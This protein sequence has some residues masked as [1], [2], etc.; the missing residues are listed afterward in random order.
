ML[1]N[2]IPKM[3]KK[4]IHDIDFE[5]LKEKNIR[6]LLFDLDNTVLRVHKSIPRKDVCDLMKRLKKDFIVYIVSNNGRKKRL[7]VASEK[8]D[9]PYVKFAMKPLPRGFKKIKKKHALLKSEMCIIG[10]QLMT[11]VLGGN[12]YGIYTIL[13]DP[14]SNDEL[15]V[16]GVNRTLEKI[17]LRKLGKKNLFKRGEYYG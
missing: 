16:T 12:R 6:C 10:D 4:S 1:K 8:L 5:S 14:L 2:Y 7:S 9:I 17:K 13:V 3:Y 11:D 15:K